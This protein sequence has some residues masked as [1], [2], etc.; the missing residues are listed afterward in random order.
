MDRRIGKGLLLLV[1]VLFIFDAPP[2]PDRAWACPAD[3]VARAKVNGEDVVHIGFDPDY[4]SVGLSFSGI[5]PSG[6]SYDP[7]DG[8]SAG[9]G[10]V[11]WEWYWP[12]Y[13]WSTAPTF[14][15]TL[16]NPAAQK[17]W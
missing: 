4:R 7:D 16:D 13:T 17:M 2:G 8:Y 11:K 1:V 5:H 6:F 15:R 3:P 10:I 12:G 9:A 14:S